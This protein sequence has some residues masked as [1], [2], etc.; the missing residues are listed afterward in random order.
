[1]GGGI[2]SKADHTKDAEKRG[3]Y[4]KTKGTQRP[5]AGSRE[6]GHSSGPQQA[7]RAS[8]GYLDLIL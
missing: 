2:P 1:M 7:L 8:L 6:A 4:T 3:Y 5:R